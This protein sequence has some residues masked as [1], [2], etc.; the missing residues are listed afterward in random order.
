[1]NDDTKKHIKK[2]ALRVLES[3][4]RLTLPVNIKEIAKAYP[5]CQC[6]VIPYSTF[7]EV[8][9]LTYAQ[10]VDQAGSDDACAN[11]DAK[12]KLAIIQYNDLNHFSIETNRYRWNI[13]HELGHIALGH[14]E[15][16]ASSKLF[17]NTMSG[18]E[19]QQ[20]EDEADCFAAYILVPHAALAVLD[21]KT[22]VDIQ[23]VCR[24]SKQAASYRM[25]EYRKWYGNS[26]FEDEYD[27]EILKC[28]FD[29]LDKQYKAIY[30]ACTHC[31]AQMLVNQMYCSICG[32]IFK[33]KV[34]GDEIVKYKE[35]RKNKNGQIQECLVCGNEVFLDDGDFC[36][37]CG[38]P[39]TN[40]C[41]ADEERNS[42]YCAPCSVSEDKDIPLNARYCPYCGGRTLFGRSGVLKSWE[43]EKREPPKFVDIEDESIDEAAY[44]PIDE[45]SL[46]F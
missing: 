43:E 28:F 6:R 41:A 33:N 42:D 1:M 37:I 24:I 12:N 45:R 11:Y 27:V 15:R 29:A 14:H 2:T 39:I 25:K 19:Y 7:M 36:H 17:R 32:G 22:A 8:T 3:A 30:R 4:P 10:V 20:A 26:R 18:R 46:P 16:Y 40:R 21:V 44:E 13:A 23:K 38:K 9:H 5:I 35:Y 31:G 34:R